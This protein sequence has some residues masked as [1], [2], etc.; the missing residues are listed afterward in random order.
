MELVVH[1]VHCTHYA[2]RLRVMVIVHMNESPNFWSKLAESDKKNAFPFGK[3]IFVYLPYCS[4][5]AFFII[6]FAYFV[7]KSLKTKS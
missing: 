1:I 2:V 6:T 5:L 7:N 4:R 3:S